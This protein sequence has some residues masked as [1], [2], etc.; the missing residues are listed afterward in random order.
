MDTRAERARQRKRQRTIRMALTVFCALMVAI[1]I[2][3]VVLLFRQ[4]A[5]TVV[6]VKLLG[7]S[8]ITLEVGERYT[9]SG[10]EAK[11]FNKKKPEKF[12]KL[13]PKVTG[14]VDTTKV[15]T[16]EIVY[17]ATYQ[18]REDSVTRVVH[19]VD[20]QLP[21]ITLQSDPAVFTLPG[22][23]YQEEG[24]TATDNYDGDLTDQVIRKEENGMV[25]YTVT[26]SS[27]NT[28][29]AQ[30][31]VVYGDPA[32]PKMTLLGDAYLTMKA[33]K[34]F[35]DPGC[36]AVDD[37]MGD[38]TDTI[39]VEGYVD[40]FTPGT[41]VLTYSATDEFENTGV[42]SRTVVV[43][44]FD[45]ADCAP[46]NGKVI[47]LTFDDGPS[48]HTERLLDVLAQYNVKATFFVVD[49]GGYYSTLTRA[50]AEGHTVA[51]HTAT[52]RFDQVYASE[53][54]YFADLE[55]MQGI[56]EQ[57]TGIK[58]MLLRFP[59]G[60]SNTL[61]A[62][63][64]R[65]IMTRLVQAV[66]ERGYHYFDWNVDSQDAG[67]ASSAE[68]VFRNV[69]NGV[70][71]CRNAVVLQHDTHWFSVDAVEKI[72]IWGLMNGY[73]F[74]PITADSPGAHHGVYN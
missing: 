3:S 52:H 73:T 28:A 49:S 31:L 10:A 7:E 12:G 58:P 32:A 37:V 47:Y 6:Q 43:L 51:I 24:F 40:G 2:T 13:Q 22:Q 17:T 48:R 59:G 50:A 60:S 61:S 39:T 45:P 44:P 23:P 46:P 34:D 29:T 68:E 19:V 72:I 71:G 21:V 36:T 53:S 26:D 38:I 63:Y 62:Q 25:Y 9:E 74:Q 8:E 1:L 56:I 69:I 54:A 65:G 57:Y 30:R 64:N 41:Y 35:V 33:G 70:S 14:E 15:G 11:Y 67:G 18:K 4:K 27:G 16:Y 55:K 66:T 20:T 42:V 5:N